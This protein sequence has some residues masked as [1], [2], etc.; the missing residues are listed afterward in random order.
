[1]ITVRTNN[2]DE[3][4]MSLDEAMLLQ[5]E[6]AKTIAHATK[7][8]F[9]SFTLASVIEEDFTRRVGKVVFDVSTEGS[10]A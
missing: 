7:H 9:S 1:M 2:C 10:S 3:I 8:K 4:C 5:I 6:L